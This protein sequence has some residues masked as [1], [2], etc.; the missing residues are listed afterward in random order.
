LFS[1]I[2][3][4]YNASDSKLEGAI[5]FHLTHD[6]ESLD[7]YARIGEEMVVAPGVVDN[8]TASLTASLF[9]WFDLAAG[10]LNP[11]L[12]AVTQKL[13][14]AGD[15]SYFSQVMS[16]SSSDVDL[17]AYQDPVTAFETDPTEHWKKPQ[18]ILVVN[19]SPRKERG[20][21]HFSIQPF[22]EGLKTSGADVEVIL[23]REYDLKLCIGCW[24][25]WIKGTGQCVLDDDLQQL[26]SKY[27]ACDMVV[28]A[29]PLYVDGLPAR[30][31]ILLERLGAG[32]YP[33]MIP[34]RYKTRHPRRRK[35][36]RSL[37]LFST[38]GFPEFEHFD[39]VREHVRA[40]AHNAHMPVVAE[41]LR[42]GG[43]NLYNNP[44]HYEMLIQV[45]DTLQE[46]GAQVV[47][48]GRVAKKRLKT[49]AQA[50]DSVDEF[51]A[52]ANRFWDEIIRESKAPY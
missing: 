39:A 3:A 16:G 35:K 47:E 13:N 28:M 24:N 10:R 17:S 45:L 40:W 38:C 50:P 41:V 26:L 5:Q 6:G 51:Q 42:P 4:T 34:G 43:M 9:D 32:C 48:G 23:L 1:H 11:V 27:D 2:V 21:T 49:I 15:T 30:I 25:C 12:G 33:Y 46:A 37:V 29:F 8:P 18:K 52:N 22:V 31:K 19:G 36:E 14:F 44:L 20:Y 7:Y